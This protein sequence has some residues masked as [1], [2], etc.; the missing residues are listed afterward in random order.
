[1]SFKALF[2]TLNS[3][4]FGKLWFAGGLVV[5]LIVTLVVMRSRSKAAAPTTSVPTATAR[6]GE[7]LV[8]VSC[9]GELTADNTARVNAPVN[10]PNLQIVWLAPQGSAVKKG[11]PVV[12]FDASGT[13][14][15]LKEQEAALAQAQAALD[16]AVAE[17]R[18]TT[19]Q[20][21]LDY[22]TQKQA[23]EK[24]RLEASK[25][26]IVSEIQAKE[27]LID[28]GLA[29][30]KVRVQQA[31]MELNAAS[32]RSKVGSLQSQR[33]KAK[34]QVDIT[35][36]RLA[37]MEV[38]APAAGVIS[39]LMNFSQG[40]MNAKPFKVGDNLWPGSAIAEIPD[41]GSLRLKGKVEEIDRGK[42]QLGQPV[43]VMLDP[44]PEKPFQ[45][46]LE[47]I[48]PL[49]ERTF[50]WPPSRSFRAFGSLGAPDDRLRPAMN[51]RMDVIV[52]RLKNAI[53][54]P[55][56]AV[57]AHDGR[58]VVLVL[59]KEGLRSVRVEVLARNPDEV[60]ISGINE[61]TQVALVDTLSLEKKKNAESKGFEVKA[62]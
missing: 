17:G 20:D 5:V 22:A 59:A 47:E 56:K 31:T 16:Q 51:G 58:P 30:E 19:E 25:K 55:A 26:D 1:V 7:F 8:I 33:D 9:R 57:F 46:K 44:F 11:D 6:R 42:L 18:I 50:E 62:R 13:Q 43:R 28:L 3:R 41:L 49:T 39:Y 61:G 60:A 4:R 40:W 15:Q 52:D 37:A 10:V 32:N 54:V 36:Q 48:S 27:N 23:A 21:K 12:R 24:A 14:R 29:E 34:Q 35:R 2:A 38:R 53:S 45:G